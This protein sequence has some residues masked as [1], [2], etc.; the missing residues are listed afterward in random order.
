M[1]EPEPDRAALAAHVEAFREA[2][3]F[4]GDVGTMAFADDPEVQTRLARLVLAGDKRATA[5]LADDP[6]GTPVAEVGQH[7]VV[8]D[9]DGTP[10]CTIRT[11]QVRVRP[12]GE[13]DPAFA[14][15]EGEG[16]RTL[17]AWTDAHA[18][19]FQRHLA[20]V[21]REL[22]D[23]TPVAFERF[24][25]VWP[26]LAP[27]PPLVEAGR[28]VVRSVRPDDR[29]W[30]RTVTG[31]VTADDGWSTDRCPGLLARHGG[32]TA[33]VLVFVPSAA[34]TEVV[35]TSRLDEVAGVE[36]VLRAGLDRLRRRYRWGTVDD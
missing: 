16:D 17:G 10:Q 18:A 13:R 31:D 36:D 1:P 4:A 28:L 34:R 14:W 11:A 33:G 24:T 23:A 15:D 27:A 12:F 3:G 2:T 21:G 19:Y 25:V 32:R 6:D 29:P 22:T 8:L 26:E 20:A 7:D 35:A 5:G 30:V 9:G